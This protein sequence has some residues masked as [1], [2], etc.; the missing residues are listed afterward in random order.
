MDQPAG[1]K[2]LCTPCLKVNTNFGNG[3]SARAL[4]CFRTVTKWLQ[5]MA[6]H[7]K[8]RMYCSDI[9]DERSTTLSRI[10]KAPDH[11]YSDRWL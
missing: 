6:T 1:M 8:M 10:W 3:W 5:R 11:G 7:K 2:N 4:K 9:Q